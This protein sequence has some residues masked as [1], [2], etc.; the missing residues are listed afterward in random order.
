M[1]NLSYRYAVSVIVPIYNVEA[2]IE[3][4]VISLFE[5]DF[6]AI[7]YIFVDDASPDNSVAILQNVISR[8][9]QRA[10]HIH[11]IHN[12]K[13]LGLFE[14]R[15][16]GVLAATG[17]YIQHV[18]SDDW[19]EE[20][21]VSSVYSVAKKQNAEVV[22]CDYYIESKK[23]AYRKQHHLTGYE[24]LLFAFLHGRIGPNVW[25]RL[26]RRKTHLLLY[27][28]LNLHK[29]INSTE[30]WLI[31]LPLYCLHNRIHY[32]PRALY[33]YNRLNNTSLTNQ[34][35]VVLYNEKVFVLLFL[36]NFFK[37]HLDNRRFSLLK[38]RFAL[39]ALG[40]SLR[41]NRHPDMDLLQQFDFSLLRL[42]Q[43]TVPQF[44]QKLVYS[45]YFLNLPWIPRIL[46]KIRQ[47]I[48]K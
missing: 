28:E 7:E 13:N 19:L 34:P 26:I 24:K 48:Q 18:D 40:A 10:E 36:H 21:M 44:R 5:Q 3:R 29:K 12:A 20:D 14:T 22:A 32:V 47:V 42:W 6:D 37:N 9:P 46:Q 17:E 1:N 45:F 8:Y 39:A 33:H 35:S 2:F 41:M 25:S 15:K 16:I 23:Q 43:S 4:C 38:D 30:D 31:T 27:R 11:I